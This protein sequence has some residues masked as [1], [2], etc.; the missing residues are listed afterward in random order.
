MFIST[1]IPDRSRC[2]GRSQRRRGAPRRHRPHHPVWL[3]LAARRQLPV[4]LR[5]WQRHLRTS[6]GCCQEP[7]RCKCS[8]MLPILLSGCNI[9]VQVSKCVL[10]LKPRSCS[11]W[12][13]KSFDNA[14]THFS[15]ICLGVP[16]YKIDQKCYCHVIISNLQENPELEIT[17]G[18]KYTSPEGVPVEL[19][20]IAN[21]NG[22]QPQVNMKFSTM[23][24]TVITSFLV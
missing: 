10:K 23:S 16:C 18:V 15:W 20:Y 4:Q 14:Q 9:I 11:A 3:R 21:E 2:C 8:Q 5:N 24:L 7:Q 17:G 12:R 1:E 6:F 19:T 13:S 22:Y